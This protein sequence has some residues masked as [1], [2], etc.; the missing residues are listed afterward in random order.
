MGL[1]DVEF[2]CN[3]KFNYDQFLA[4]FPEQ[5]KIRNEVCNGAFNRHCGGFA[6][7]KLFKITQDFR[8]FTAVESG[9][10]GLANVLENVVVTPGK[11]TFFKGDGTMIENMVYSCS[12]LTETA[13]DPR[14]GKTELVLHYYTIIIF[15]VIL[16]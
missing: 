11:S 16:C 4:W 13:F 15:L 8:T 7:D 10:N 14:R 2:K 1:F 3:S 5:T 9:N 6:V 12:V